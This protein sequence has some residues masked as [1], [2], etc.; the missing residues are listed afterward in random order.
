MSC[1]NWIDSRVQVAKISGELKME[2]D[3]S[4]GVMSV[5]QDMSENNLHVMLNTTM[6]SADSDEKPWTHAILFM[7]YKNPDMCLAQINHLR[8]L[9]PSIPIYGLYS[10][11]A[12]EL[13][14][15]QDVV[16]ALNDFWAHPL[17]GPHADPVHNWLNQDQMIV[18]WFLARGQHLPWDA[19]IY[20]QWDILFLEPILKFAAITH[21]KEFAYFLPPLPT[22]HMKLMGW[23]SAICPEHDRFWGVL[24]TYFPD[25]NYSSAGPLLYMTLSR[26]FIEEAHAI[27]SVLPGWMEYRIPTVC[28][29]L[30]YTW[31]DRNIPPHWLQ[32]SNFTKQDIPAETILTEFRKPEGCRIFHPVNAD[33]HLL[34]VKASL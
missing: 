26:R 20:H 10:G 4:S 28:A 34:Q 18:N 15:F 12:Q 5:N 1:D 22:L 21:P 16:N 2:G 30:G 3:C 14:K 13:S 19:L 8:Q 7:L 33:Y 25:L 24:Q 27:L 11:P 23:P 32:H 9:N 17:E 31:V 29:A 6:A